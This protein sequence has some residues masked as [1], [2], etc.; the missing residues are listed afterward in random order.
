MLSMTP[1]GAKKSERQYPGGLQVGS[2]DSKVD[3]HVVSRGLKSRD[4]DN[5]I[6]ANII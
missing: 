3:S 4:V 1:P 5:R 2:S 6:S